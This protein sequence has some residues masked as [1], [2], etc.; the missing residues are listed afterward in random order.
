MKQAIYRGAS[1]PKKSVPNVYSGTAV[2][3]FMLRV[4]GNNFVTGFNKNL[5]PFISYHIINCGTSW[6]IN[7]NRSAPNNANTICK[8]HFWLFHP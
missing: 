1:A 3:I 7:E 2:K 4:T 8:T 6:L 5:I